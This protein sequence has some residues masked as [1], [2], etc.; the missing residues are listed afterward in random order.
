M[1]SISVCEVFY[2]QNHYNSIQAYP[3]PGS[4]V[5]DNRTILIAA[6]YLGLLYFFTL[7]KQTSH[8]IAGVKE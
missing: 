2:P 7:S 4:S 3:T 6:K 5:L 8:Q 1:A